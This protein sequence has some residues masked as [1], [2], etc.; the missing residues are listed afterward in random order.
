MVMAASLVAALARR[1]KPTVIISWALVGVGVV[2]SAMAP[3]TAPWQL[4][5]ALFAVG[6]FMTPLHA[7]VATLVQTEV[8]DELRGRTSS[9]LNT[10]IT[11]ANVTSMALAGTAAT[12]LG[13]RTVFVVAG[14]ICAAAG[15]V[16]AFLFRGVELAQPAEAVA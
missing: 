4:M 10:V 11:A 5:I 9:A 12:F 7:S 13:L 16:T 2:A 6:W 15:V 3:V 1:I 8:E 14:A